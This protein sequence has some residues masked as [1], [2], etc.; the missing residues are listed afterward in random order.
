RHTFASH[1][2]MNGGNILVLQKILG[3]ADI[4]MTMRY[5]HFAPSHLEDAVRLN[6]LKCRKNVATA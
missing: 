4:T 2:M 6:P 1:F 3:H 5:A